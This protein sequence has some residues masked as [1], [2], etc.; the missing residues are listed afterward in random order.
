MRRTAPPRGARSP[1]GRPARR[2]HPSPRA[3]CGRAP[4]ARPGAAPP[5]RPPRRPA[6]G[7][8]RRPAPRRRCATPIASPPRPRAARAWGLVPQLERSSARRRRPSSVFSSS[9][10]PVRVNAMACSRSTEATFAC[11]SSTEPSSVGTERR[12]GSTSTSKKKC[13]SPI[14][15]GAGNV[16]GPSARMASG[17]TVAPISS[18]QLARDAAP[19]ALGA[20]LVGLDQA[21]GQLPERAERVLLDDGARLPRP[22]R[23]RR[24]QRGPEDHPPPP[25]GVPVVRG[26]HD[27][28]EPLAI[29]GVRTGTAR[30]GSHRRRRRA[31]SSA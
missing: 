16:L 28:V 13:R 4:R 25:A 10:S 7:A 29:D 2:A 17:A 5:W 30:C 15:P 31:G 14:T 11:C 18:A 27:G 24:P 21:G 19:Q 26:H 23:H 22:H 1:C 9:I 12:D 20:P 3:P 8:A 6:R